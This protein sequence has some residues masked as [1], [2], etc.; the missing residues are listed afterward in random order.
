[1]A[2]VNDARFPDIRRLA[3]LSALTIPCTGPQVAP[4]VETRARLDAAGERLCRGRRRL[5]R[6]GARTTGANHGL[7]HFYGDPR[8]GRFVGAEMVVPGAGYLARALAS[9]LTVT[10]I[11]DRPLHHTVLGEGLRTALRDLNAAMGAGSPGPARCLDAGPGSRS[12]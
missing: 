5:G 3:R 6:R 10:Q 9:G 7:P 1:M 2:G 12:L 8:K 4:V 11:L